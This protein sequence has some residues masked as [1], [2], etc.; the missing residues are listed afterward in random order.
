MRRALDAILNVLGL[1]KA[2]DFQP[3]ISSAQTIAAIERATPDRSWNA[4]DCNGQLTFVAK[5]P[6]LEPFALI[7]QVE[8]NAF[9]ALTTIQLN[10]AA[11]VTEASFVAPGNPGFSMAAE[12]STAYRGLVNTVTN[13]GD[14]PQPLTKDEIGKRLRSQDCADGCSHA[15]REF[16]GAEEYRRGFESL[17]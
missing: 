7:V 16:L 11:E 3:T 8:R 17:Q 6:G 13:L 4:F 15:L 1:G 5:R 9:A 10:G 2:E 12:T 14:T